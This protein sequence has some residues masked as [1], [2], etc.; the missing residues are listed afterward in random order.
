[1]QSNFTQLLPQ[2]CLIEHLVWQESLDEVFKVDTATVVRV[3]PP[4]NTLQLMQLNAESQPLE[5]L[6]Q[7]FFRDLGRALVTLY[8]LESCVKRTVNRVKLG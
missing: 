3:N 8:L 5:I 1:M 2:R 4:N 7:G 6:G